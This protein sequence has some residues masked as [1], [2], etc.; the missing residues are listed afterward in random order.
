MTCIVGLVEDGKVYI[1][2]DSAGVGGYSLT[3]RK[4]RKVFRNGEFIIGGTSSFRMIQLLRY[5]LTPPTIEDDE[6]IER[7]MATKFIDAVRECLKN[8]GFAQKTSDQESGGFFLVGVRGR[9]F[10]IASDYQVGEP[11][12]GYDAVGC[13]D[14]IALGSL[15]ATPDMQSVKRIEMALK[16]AERH[17]AGVRAPFYWE[18]L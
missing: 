14:D 6:G 10:Q 8:G 15:Y 4:D 13:G 2:G 7:Y 12:D 3:V 9:L 16:A 17:N 11:L 1:G 5:S 18:V